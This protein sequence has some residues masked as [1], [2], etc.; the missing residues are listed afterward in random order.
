MKKSLKISLGGVAFIVEDDAYAAL[1]SYLELLKEYL[2]ATVESEEVINDIEDRAAELLTD[3]LKGK[4]VVTL[5]MVEQVI[6]I[7]GKPEEIAGEDVDN[8]SSFASAD[9]KPRRRLFRDSENALIAGVCSGLGVYFN[10]DVLV[11]RILFAVLV[12]ANGL[13]LVLYL[14]LWIIVPGA[15]SSRQRMEMRGEKVT[16]SNLEKNIKEEFQNVRNN[17]EKNKVSEKIEQF[18][19]AS[20]PVF[21]AFGRAMAVVAK[22]LV[23]FVAL[24]FIC[25][26]LFGLAVTFVTLFF[27]DALVSFVPNFSGF[28]FGQ[29]IASTFDL[30]SSLWVTVPTFLILAIPFTVF[31]VAGLRMI[32]KFTARIGAFLVSLAILW[33][34]AVMILASVTFFQFR[35]FTIRESVTERFDISLSDT[36]TRVLKVFAD[37]NLDDELIISN[38]VFNSDDYSIVQANGSIQFVGRPK[39]SIAKSSTDRFELLITKKSRGGSRLMAK[40]SASRVEQK[41]TLV[42]N[43]LI[44][45]PYF[46]VHPDLKWRVQEV[47]IVLYVPEG[48]GVYFDQ[49]LEHV[50]NQE[51]SYLNAWPDEIVANTWIMRVNTMERQ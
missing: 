32:F 39:I 15:Q 1:D 38:Q 49:N 50:I 4:A 31:V 36:T 12:F 46:M 8:E 16:F 14:I 30:G 27:G 10:V 34:L 3:M 47:D 33:I 20:G 37:E 51:Q 41:F 9:D 40:Q 26:G 28:S 43:S 23:V 2:G 42:D 35:S 21:V 19:R 7:L 24:V 5:E 44:I 22:V 6:A 11:F 17:M 29:L 13:G 45:T 25:V 48:K 18:F